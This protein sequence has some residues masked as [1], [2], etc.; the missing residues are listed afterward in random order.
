MDIDITVVPQLAAQKQTATLRSTTHRSIFG[1][2]ETE[3]DDLQPSTW[4][5][6]HMKAGPGSNEE[7]MFSVTAK[8]LPY[9]KPE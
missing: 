7:Q 3:S 2:K 9:T 8:Y 4:G 5:Q 1:F 6:W